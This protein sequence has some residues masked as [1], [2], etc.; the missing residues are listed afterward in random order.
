MSIRTNAHQKSI[1]VRAAALAV[2]LGAM[3]SVGT[4]QAR[5]SYMDEIR[6]PDCTFC[7]VGAMGSKSFT[8]DGQIFKEKLIRDRRLRPDA[9]PAGQPCNMQTINLFDQQGNFM[10]KW[11]HCVP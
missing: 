5:P 11:T 1:A 10:Q 6:A 8:Q 4:A 7:H 3:L 9:A 2:G